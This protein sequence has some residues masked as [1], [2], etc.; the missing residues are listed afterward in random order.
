MFQNYV[1]N[2]CLFFYKQT[3]IS[4]FI[5][6]YNYKPHCNILVH[7]QIYQIYYAITLIKIK[8]VEGTSENKIKRCFKSN[9]CYFNQ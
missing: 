8:F 6:F 1:Y 7:F 5:I 2:T 9:I 4:Y 3:E